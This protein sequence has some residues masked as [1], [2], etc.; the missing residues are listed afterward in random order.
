[1]ENKYVVA[2]RRLYSVNSEGWLSS[3]NDIEIDETPSLSPANT[4]CWVS[5]WV[6]VPKEEIEE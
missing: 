5:A 1:M 4:G 6:W 3:T 2:A